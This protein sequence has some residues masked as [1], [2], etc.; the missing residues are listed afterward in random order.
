MLER[1]TEPDS[2]NLIRRIIIRLYRFSF[3]IKRY[4]GEGDFKLN[5]DIALLASPTRQGWCGGARQDGIS[6]TV[7]AARPLRDRNHN[8]KKTLKRDLKGGR[9]A[10]LRCSFVS[11]AQPHPNEL[12]EMGG[13]KK[14]IPSVKH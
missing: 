9:S 2:D 10:I 6:G 11:M 14:I 13:E 5:I 12:Q 8:I 1:F 4:L 3:S 7:K